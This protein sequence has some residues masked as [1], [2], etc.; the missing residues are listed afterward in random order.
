MTARWRWCSATAWTMTAAQHGNGMVHIAWRAD[1]SGPMTD[2]EYRSMRQPRAGT[3][4]QGPQT[5]HPVRFGI[6]KK[7]DQFQLYIS[8]QGEALHPEGVPVIFKTNGPVYVGLG[9]CS[10]LA[11]NVLTARVRDVVLDN[12]A[13]KVR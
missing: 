13:G 9:F 11:A 4:E 2:V 8:W 12:E 5:F 3:A 10:H 1:K 6:E 7:G